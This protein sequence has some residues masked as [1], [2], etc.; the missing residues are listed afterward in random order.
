MKSTAFLAAA[1]AF[2]IPGIAQAQDMRDPAPGG[3][4][5]DPRGD[6]VAT[7]VSVDQ[8]T[9]TAVVDTGTRR[10]TVLLATFGQ[11]TRGPMLV[12]TRA[13]LDELILAA[14]TAQANALNAAIVPA[15][16]VFDANGAPLGAITEV[17]ATG[18]VLVEGVAGTFYLPRT[19]FRLVS[20]QLQALVSTADVT[21]QLAAKK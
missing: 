21:A 12:T 2:A 20:S 11:S 5:V 3:Q 1:L 8:A 18:M 17:T 14:E 9:G 16:A 10:G 4:V 13:Q 7:I 19:G 6:Y 15:A